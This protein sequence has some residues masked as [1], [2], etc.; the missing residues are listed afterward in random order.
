L[1]QK[2]WKKPFLKN[3]RSLEISG[4]RVRDD[5]ASGNF[6]LGEKNTCFGSPNAQNTTPTPVI[7]LCWC[8]MPRGPLLLLHQ[9]PAKTLGIWLAI[10]YAYIAYYL[11]LVINGELG[12]LAL[13]HQH[14]IWLPC[15][16][17]PCR[18]N[19]SLQ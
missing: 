12:Q 10:Y 14:F 7:P 4:H 6:R 9:R 11:V 5:L 16:C 18:V 15:F 13:N 17:F 2:E 19:T 1:V 3:F 8:R